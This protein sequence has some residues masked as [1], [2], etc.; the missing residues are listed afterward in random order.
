[1]THRWTRHAATLGDNPR[2]Q[3]HELARPPSAL[4]LTCSGDC[5]APAM[6]APVLEPGAWRLHRTPANV[7]P[8]RGAGLAEEEAVIE[9]AVADGVSAI[10]V[11]GHTP[12]AVLERLL[13]PS[14]ASADFLLRDWLDAAEAAR[15][16][17]LADEPV[18]FARRS[19]ALV[20]HNVRAQLA[21]LLTHPTV[22][23][24][25]VRLFGWVFDH[26][27]GRLLCEGASGG[28]DRC[29]AL[30]PDQNHWLRREYRLSRRQ[31]P[32]APSLGTHR[33]Y[34]A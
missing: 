26:A 31:P 3:P 19:R 14:T 5:F 11:C 8:P 6:L 33:R 2:P 32:P 9:R 1:M 7:V 24:S 18:C 15:L 17:A 29:V 12:C 10:V 22:A 30:D 16:A 20:E 34:L 21:H 23:A 4:L 25:G 27:G 13:D 28:F